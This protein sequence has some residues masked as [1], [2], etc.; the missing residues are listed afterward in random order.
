MRLTCI[1]HINLT[2]KFVTL[3]YSFLPTWVMITTRAYAMSK[4]M[5]LY[6]CRHYW[7]HR[8]ESCKLTFVCAT[9]Q[10]WE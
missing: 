5:G 7:H 2:Q 4:V 8:H 3:R 9:L 6:V 1:I 10:S